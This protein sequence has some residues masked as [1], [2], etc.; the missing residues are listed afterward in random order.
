MAVSAEGCAAPFCRKLGGNGQAMMRYW[1]A[2]RRASG[3]AYRRAIDPLE[4]PVAILPLLQIHERR[5]DGRFVCRLAGTMIAQVYGQDPTGRTMN[6]MISGAAL[7]SRVAMFER[8]LET[9]RPI[10]YAAQLALPGRA[11]RRVERLLMPLADAAGELNAVLS[12]LT[13][14]DIEPAARG[15]AGLGQLGPVDEG[16]EASDADLAACTAA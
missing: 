2:K 13:F 10:H 3:R 16:S 9:G 11:P 7:A 1:C 8:V 5:G 15:T 4:L 12:L 14:P 6:E